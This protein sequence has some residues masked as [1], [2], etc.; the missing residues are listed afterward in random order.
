[1]EISLNNIVFVGVLHPVE[2]PC[3]EYPLSLAGGLGL[4]DEG[5]R[6]FTIK[7]N[8]EVFEILRHDPSR[9]EELV[10]L[11]ALVLHGLQVTR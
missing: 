9:W 5:F 4:D 8:L 6:L 3:Q 2:A 1:M 11:R 10:F 7:L